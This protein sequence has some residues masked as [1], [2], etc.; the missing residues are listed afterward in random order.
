MGHPLVSLRGQVDCQPCSGPWV[1]H[2]SDPPHFLLKNGDEYLPQL[3]HPPPPL[4]QQA[5]HG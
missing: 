4:C 5:D 3:P 2:D 1:G